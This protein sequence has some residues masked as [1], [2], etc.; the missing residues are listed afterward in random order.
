LKKTAIKSA[1]LGFATYWIG[2][3]W[4]G[5]HEHFA[6]RSD[7]PGWIVDRPIYEPAAITAWCGLIVFVAAC[8]W[9]IV[10]WISRLLEDKFSPPQKP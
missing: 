2:V 10:F 7:P 1:I 4:I 3:A 5:V 9:G 6:K 8:A